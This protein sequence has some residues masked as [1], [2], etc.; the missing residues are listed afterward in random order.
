MAQFSC[1][2]HVV[3]TVWGEL[4]EGFMA[5][6]VLSFAFALLATTA[7]ARAE[8]QFNAATVFGARESIGH[9]DLSPDGTTVTY[10]APIGG[11]ASAINIATIEGGTEK[12]IVKT[13]GE[14]DQVS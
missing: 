2:F 8:P 11:K 6:R 3:K 7:V 1:R 9:V 14:T 12:S 4:G 5:G 10:V 13:S